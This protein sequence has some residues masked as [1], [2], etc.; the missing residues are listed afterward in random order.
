MSWFRRPLRIRRPGRGV[1]ATCTALFLAGLSLSPLCACLCELQEAAGEA[2]EHAHHE[3]HDPSGHEKGHDCECGNCVELSASLQIQ[4]LSLTSSSLAPSVILA[5]IGSPW[6]P[7]ENTR[8]LVAPH[9]ADRGPPI[10]LSL[11]SIL[12]S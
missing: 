7:A 6:A 12:R 1:A 8:G 5:R 2:S 11:F 3:S 4:T 9:R 10:P